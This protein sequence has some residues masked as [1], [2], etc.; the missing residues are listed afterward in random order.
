[1]WWTPLGD[2]LMLADGTITATGDY[3]GWLAFCAHP[4]SRL[5]LNAYEL[6]S[7]EQEAEH[8]LLVDRHP[9]TLDVGLAHD[10]RALLATQPC[11]LHALTAELSPTEA[12]ALL[13]HAFEDHAARE[14][15]KTPSSAEATCANGASA[16]RS[17][18]E[19]SRRVST[20]RCRPS[21]SS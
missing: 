14:H 13:E 1:M 21:W 19:S 7:S 3:R 17:S 5:F 2:E 9:G 12:A 8:W 20:R 4:L 6:G 11:E 10:V 15:A 18:S 16:S